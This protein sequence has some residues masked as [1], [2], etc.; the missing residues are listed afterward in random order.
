VC[1]ALLL[2]LF[3]QSCLNSSIYAATHDGRQA[4]GAQPMAHT[5]ADP[6]APHQTSSS[7]PPI[8]RS[9]DKRSLEACSCAS[10]KLAGIKQ[11]LSMCAPVRK[12]ASETVEAGLAFAA[13]Y[14]TRLFAGLLHNCTPAHHRK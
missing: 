8:K 14:E 4:Q 13:S 3:L 6:V 7:K 12:A 10:K 1:F 5:A 9:S 2:V 11:E